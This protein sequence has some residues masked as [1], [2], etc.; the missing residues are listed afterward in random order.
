[1]ISVR[2]IF[3]HRALRQTTHAIRVPSP[4]MVA[5]GPN[6]S[7]SL[8]G[9]DPVTLLFMWIYAG[10]RSREWTEYLIHHVGAAAVFLFTSTGVHRSLS[11]SLT[12]D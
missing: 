3:W 7:T 9:I 5:R 2:H 6:N 12:L 10:L 11:L 1:M 8:S 4:Y